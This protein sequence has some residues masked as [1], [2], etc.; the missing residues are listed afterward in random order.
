MVMLEIEDKLIKL[1]KEGSTFSKL[2]TKTGLCSSELVKKMNTLKN[3][4]YIIDRE[5]ND[6]VV[7][8]IISDKLIDV[9]QD[10]IR[11]NM[12]NKFTFLVLA[13]THIGNV[14]ENMSL[15]KKI[16]KYAEEHNIRY[17]FHLGDMVE[18]TSLKESKD[19]RIKRNTVEDQIDYVTRNYPKSDF[20]NTLYILGNHDNRWL[21]E[22]IDIATII[23]KRR[24]DMHFLGYKNS[25]VVVGNYQILLHHP[26]AIERDHKYDK[27]VKDLYPNSRFDLILRG[28]THHN[29]IYMNEDNGII[30]NVPA[31]YDSPSLKYIGAY[32]ITLKNEQLEL[33]QLIVDNEVETFSNIKLQ[34]D[35]R[36]DN[37][38]LSDNITKNKK[39]VK[40]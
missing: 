14:N 24:Y 16:Y 7:K 25:R 9:L 19:L 28:H 29:S 2:K 3:K 36:K 40:I 18:G 27:E 5:F 33:T 11:I 34:Y 13:D 6:Q 21:N 22:G 1:L 37:E 15:V 20:I 4:G 38:C 39:K 17:V 32:M 12:D 31:C 8:F 30:V 35:S 10:N 26:F 23:D